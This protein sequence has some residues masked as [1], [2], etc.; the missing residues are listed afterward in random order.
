MTNEEYLR[1]KGWCVSVRGDAG[2]YGPDGKIAEWVSLAEAVEHQ[3]AEDRACYN[4]MRERSG[5]YGG[6]LS[7]AAGYE[8]MTIATLAGAEVVAVTRPEGGETI[9]VDERRWTRDGLTW[10]ADLGIFRITIEPAAGGMVRADAMLNTGKASSASVKIGFYA[11]EETA[12]WQ[13]PRDLRAKVLAGL[14]EQR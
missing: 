14:P 5:I 1:A 6:L 12:K 9:V 10:W 13:A 2:K 7:S 11:D 3:L 8:T 4:F